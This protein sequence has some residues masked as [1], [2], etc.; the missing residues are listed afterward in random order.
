MAVWLFIA[1]VFP[2]RAAD[3]LFETAP[4]VTVEQTRTTGHTALLTNRSRPI[5]PSRYVPS[6]LT[7]VYGVYLTAPAAS[8]LRDLV[9]AASRNGHSLRVVSG[10]RSYDRQQQL[11]NAYVS[12]YGQAYADSI[13]A[14]PGTSEHQLG[15]AVDVGSLSGSFGSSPAGRWVAAHAHEFGFVIRYPQGL[16]HI[17]GYRYEPWHLRY[18]GKPLAQHLTSSR[19]PTYE[20]YVSALTT[21]EATPR[22]DTVGHT[23]KRSID[24]LY[25][26]HITGGYSNG[27]FGP[28]DPVSRLE[29]ATFLYRYASRYPAAQTGAPPTQPP[30]VGIGIDH[31]YAEELGWSKRW[32]I[33]NGYTDGSFG[34]G[35]PITR[36][37]LAAFLMNYAENVH[38][39]SA[40]EPP[41]SSPFTD[42]RPGGA[43]YEAITWLASTRITGGYA[44]GA[45]RP[46]K[47]TTRGEI[48]AFLQRL[49]TYLR[50]HAS[51]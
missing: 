29:M 36:G 37:Q 8:A 34:T 21:W 38:G 5:S 13:S 17:T 44:D 1:G 33:A 26:Q 4:P 24:W 42:V 48:A 50:H 41:R 47:T 43:H 40:P 28:D 18:L 10:Y 23:F 22:P 16:E 11:Y 45:F 2:A 51:A 6:H 15:L 12:Q 30:Y 39:V 7:S 20:Q 27:L 19:Y 46:W 32:R 14:L 9:G 25:S 35:D 49:D 31:S 3:P